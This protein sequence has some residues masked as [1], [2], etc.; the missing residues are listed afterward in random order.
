MKKWSFL[1][2]SL[3]LFACSSSPLS[4]RK[5]DSAEIT[6]LLM[7]YGLEEVE[8]REGDTFFQR[9]YSGWVDRAR[10]DVCVYTYENG[11]VM[12]IDLTAEGRVDRDF[13]YQI[14]DLASKGEWAHKRLCEKLRELLDNEA[15]GK[16]SFRNDSLKLD[17]DVSISR[18]T[19]SLEDIAF[20]S[21][22]KENTHE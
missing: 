8:R 14:C 21:W 9:S 11:E 10:Y 19:I 13:L 22:L 5:S 17:A 4:L 16:L 18:I 2:L 7:G 3:F 6:D 15:G 12:D 1:F 20:E